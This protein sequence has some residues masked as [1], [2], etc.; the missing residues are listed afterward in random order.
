M[1]GQDYLVI[2]LAVVALVVLIQKLRKKPEAG[3]DKCDPV[4]KAVKK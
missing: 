2:A 3:C 4:S 1:S